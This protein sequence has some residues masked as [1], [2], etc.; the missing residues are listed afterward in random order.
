MEIQ[1]LEARYIDG[2]ALLA[3]LLRLFGQGNF[4]IDVSW[5]EEHVETRLTNITLE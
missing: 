2:A 1:T 3:L 5:P 4:T